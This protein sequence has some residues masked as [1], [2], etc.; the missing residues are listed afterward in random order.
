MSAA[1]AE[2][3][4]VEAIEH[5]AGSDQFT[6]K[7]RGELSNAAVAVDRIVI[8]KW[9]RRGLEQLASIRLSRP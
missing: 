7:Y 5:V 1:L 3:P 6:I 9:L 4:H 2:L 8:V